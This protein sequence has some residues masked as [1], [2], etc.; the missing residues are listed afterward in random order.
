[1]GFSAKAAR[2]G[3][4]LG[5]TAPIAAERSV[6]PSSPR[7]THFGI[8]GI[9]I[10]GIPIVCFADVGTVEKPTS[11]DA[12]SADSIYARI[13]VVGP[14]RITLIDPLGRRDTWTAPGRAMQAEDP[15]LREIPG[16]SQYE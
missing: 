7:W 11:G 6:L 16:C 8:L 13:L 14:G 10:V 2:S 5:S 1:M 4:R 15:V 12:S 9:F 3:T